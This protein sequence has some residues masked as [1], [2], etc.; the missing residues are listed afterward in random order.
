MPVQVVFDRVEDA[1][2]QIQRRSA[3]LEKAKAMFDDNTLI[4]AKRV[5]KSWI[6]KGR[7]HEVERVVALQQLVH[8][9]IS[10]GEGDGMLCACMDK[11]TLKD[12]DLQK[13]TLAYQ[14]QEYF[15]DVCYSVRRAEPKEAG[16]VMQ[17]IPCD[18]YDSLL[19]PLSHEHPGCKFNLVFFDMCEECLNDF[20]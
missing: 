12:F 9:K 2:R 11:L 16:L 18:H 15:K 8:S 7:K 3:R 17:L 10:W 13:G 20:L 19:V 6:I 4:V 5:D 14:L 1:R